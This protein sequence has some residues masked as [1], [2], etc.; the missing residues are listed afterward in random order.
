MAGGLSFES[1]KDMVDTYGVRDRY[2]ALP[3]AVRDVVNEK[4]FA[5]L[6]A[7]GQHQLIQDL[8]EPEPEA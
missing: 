6:G 1:F 4:E 8:T 3:A 5:W 2:A 7:Q